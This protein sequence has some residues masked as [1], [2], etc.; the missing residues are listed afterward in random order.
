MLDREAVA[1]LLGVCEALSE[2]DRER[3]FERLGLRE[4]LGNRDDEGDASSVVDA[5]AELVS[6]V[7]ALTLLLGVCRVETL[8]EGLPINVSDVERLALMLG[9]RFS[10]PLFEGVSINER[11]CVERIDAVGV[12]GK[13]TESVLGRGTVKDVREKVAELVRDREILGVIS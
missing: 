3:G 4:G 11:D 6:D 8:P 7:D 2:S 5:V 12:R 1:L 13:V 10:E 9:V